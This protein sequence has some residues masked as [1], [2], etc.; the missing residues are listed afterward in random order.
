MEPF[1]TDA[2]RA[3]SE[4][5]AVLVDETAAME[6][7]RAV[8]HYTIGNARTIVESVKERTASRRGGRP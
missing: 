6:L 4:F 5:S 7:W 8:K 1:D 2:R 3:N